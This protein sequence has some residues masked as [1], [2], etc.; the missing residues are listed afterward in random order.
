MTVK[1]QNQKLLTHRTR[2]DSF[3]YPLGLNSG[4]P[5]VNS[6]INAI[7]TPAFTASPASNKV[8]PGANGNVV[9]QMTTSG[10]FTL[11]DGVGD[12][13]GSMLIVAGGGGSQ[14]NSGGP[15][16]TPGA[17][18]GGLKYITGLTFTQGT[19]YPAVVG[20]GGAVSGYGQDSSIT[21]DSTPYSV[22]G[23]GVGG[24][25]TTA[26]GGPGGSGGGG[27]PGIP[28]EGYPGGARISPNPGINGS[29]ATM[30]GGGAGGSGG[31]YN[32]G[33]GKFFNISG[34]LVG[35]AGGGGSGNG[36]EAATI[37]HEQQNPQI[38]DTYGNG[39]QQFPGNRLAGGGVH[40]PP[41]GGGA[42][43][44]IANRGGGSGGCFGGVGQVGQGGGSGV[45]FIELDMRDNLVERNTGPGFGL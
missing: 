14:P 15:G 34:E 42:T 11:E 44:G 23:G 37:Y 20:G 13:T 7:G 39:N 6:F 41:G 28:G 45:I 2:P 35:Y 29:G 40:S 9:I 10:S 36:S 8:I 21:I 30:G 25:R 4:G 38:Y 43:G 17:G 1:F 18:A 5:D 26:A 12:Q 32:G 27:A 31:P 24:P 22:T 33:A 19:T 3:K 16:H